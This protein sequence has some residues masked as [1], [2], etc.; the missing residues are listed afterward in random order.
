[1]PRLQAAAACNPCAVARRCAAAA[2]SP[3]N[4]CN[5]CAAAARNPCNPC[6]AA[7]N[8]CG[9]CN[10]CG[11]S[12]AVQLSDAE[13]VAA[14]DCLLNEMRAAYAQSGHPVAASYSEWR[15][16]SKNA[17]VSQ[18]HGSRYVQNYAN[19]AAKAYGAFS[20]NFV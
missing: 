4:P 16:Y 20:Y 10:P 8:P 18:T 1:M 17:Y 5:P 19:P 13:A 12:G 6:A 3:C 7:G 14:Y 11:A 15:R 9:A 2:C